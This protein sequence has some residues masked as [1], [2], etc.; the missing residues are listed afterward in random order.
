[1]KQTFSK[2]AGIVPV[3]IV[4]IIA[5]GILGGGAGI[6]AVAD[7]A[8]P[9]DPLFSVDVLAEKVKG[10][11][12]FGEEARANFRTEVAQERLEEIDEMLTEK[13]VEAP[14][15]QEALGRVRQ[16]MAELDAYLAAHPEVA[17]RIRSS[18]G[19]LDDH[20]SAIEE[21]HEELEDAFEDEDEDLEDEDGNDEEDSEDAD[22]EDGDENEADDDDD[23]DSVSTS[24]STELR[25][26]AE[27]DIREVKA[28]F[29]ELQAD[30]ARF[31]IVLPAVKVSAYQT[32][33]VQ[34]DAA[35]AAGQYAQV[36]AYVDRAEEA[37]DGMESPVEEAKH[38]AQEA[39]ND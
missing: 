6:A 10:V 35:F 1:M 7:G 30:A 31:S 20:M 3:I 24:G 14:G 32:A 34:A 33:M 13:G 4:V 23:D 8:K 36:E 27:A 2:Q 25:V 22:Q 38:K 21:S 12:V 17:S 26:K 19:E 16:A 18:L 39:D 37:I 28:D 29:V 5:L 11:V 9:G 15:L